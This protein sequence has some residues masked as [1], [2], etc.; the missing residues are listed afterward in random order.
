MREAQQQAQRHAA[1]DHARE[2]YGRA[3]GQLFRDPTA[4]AAARD[5]MART[6]GG[7]VAADTL[8]RTPQ[9]FGALTAE[10]AEAL[11]RGWGRELT[12]AIERTGA[13]W[14]EAEQ[15]RPHTPAA[16]VMVQV[17]G[18]ERLLAPFRAQDRAQEQ[19]KQRA[20]R[21]LGLDRD[22]GRGR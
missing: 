12:G 18:L 1:A 13:R 21:A 8:R 9:A 3:W 7:D 10:G 5:R 16:Q 6:I 14:R 2:A 17:Q 4:A 22:R 11:A 19:V 15:E 20:E